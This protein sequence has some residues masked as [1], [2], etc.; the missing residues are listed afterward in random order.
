MLVY[1]RVSWRF[2]QHPIH[3][4]GHV[5]SKARAQKKP[6][7]PPIFAQVG[8]EWLHYEDVFLR[9]RLCFRGR[10]RSVLKKDLR[11]W[12]DFLL[13]RMFHGGQRATPLRCPLLRVSAELKHDTR[14]MYFMIFD[15]QLCNVA[16]AKRTRKTC[17]KKQPANQE[18]RW[19]ASASIDT[20]N[21]IRLVC[22][23]LGSRILSPRNWTYEYHK[24]AKYF[25]PESPWVSIRLFSGGCIIQMLH[26]F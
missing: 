10:S 11:S 6:P 17:W 26:V 8:S 15:Q 4:I 22:V 9:W 25:K 24:L 21:C 1:P 5:L 23:P 16:H 13:G 12:I 19:A 3:S 7:D 20:P 14:E 2:G 18:V